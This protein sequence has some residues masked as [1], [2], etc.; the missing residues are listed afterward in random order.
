MHGIWILATCIGQKI[1]ILSFGQ[2]KYILNEIHITDFIV[3]IF[4]ST[5]GKRIEE[6]KIR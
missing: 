4:I 3:F 5:I 1:Y 2:R 6:K